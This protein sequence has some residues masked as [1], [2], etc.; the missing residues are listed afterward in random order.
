[1]FIFFLILALIFLVSGG[2]GLFHVNVNLG[3]SS[4]IWFYGNLTFG[5]F[6][7]I[8]IAILVFMALFNTEFD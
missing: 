4:P 7:V 6:T 2:I 3:S 1:M 5:T 8:G